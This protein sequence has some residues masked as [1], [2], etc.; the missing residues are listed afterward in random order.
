[1]RSF[2]LAL[3]TYNILATLKAALASVHGVEKVEAALS[4]VYVVDEVQG[5][6]RG[7]MIAIVNRRP[8]RE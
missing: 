6:Y 2:S 5:T 7:M 8:L 1:M 3:V 4:D